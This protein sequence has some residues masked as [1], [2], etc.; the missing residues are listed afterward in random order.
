VKP[1]PFEYV[2]PE[3][4]EEAVARKADGG[5]EALVLAGGQSLIPLLSLRLASPSLLV[6]LGRIADLSY[7]RADEGSLAIGAMTR[8]REVERRGDLDGPLGLLEDAIPFIGHPAI[9]N[10]GTVGGSV[11][12]ADPAA[13]WP[14]LAMALDAT[15]EAVGPAGARNIDAADFFVG[16]FTNAL[17]PDEIV[18][19]VRLRPPGRGAGSAFVEQGRRHGDF[20]LV[21]VAAVLEADADAR[22]SRA[23]IALVGVGGGPVRAASA[24]AALTGGR[25]TEDAIAA[26]AALAEEDVDPPSSVH[27]SAAYRRHLVRVLVTRAVRI[28]GQRAG[29]A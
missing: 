6:D 21:G 7:V 14:A 2:A 24:E 28:A 16:P 10:R 20:A 13:E 1:P 27:A 18:R 23:A 5:D 17:H 11:A 29:V 3:T 15:V 12:H 8:H 19:E 26:G 9:R 25:L 22:V 4:L